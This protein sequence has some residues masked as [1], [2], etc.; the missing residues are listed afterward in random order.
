MYISAACGTLCMLKLHGCCCKASRKVTRCLAVTRHQLPLRNGHLRCPSAAQH[1]G[2]GVGRGAAVRAAG[3]GGSAAG[4][5]A[6]P[7]WRGGRHGAPRHP[8][9][10]APAAEGATHRAVAFVHSRRGWVMQSDVGTAGQLQSAYMH[11]NMSQAPVATSQ[12][13]QCVILKMPAHRCSWTTRSW[14]TCG[15][16]RRR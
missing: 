11:W 3:P 2:V 9:V 13:A 8:G 7:R 4:N 12:S 1:G 16:P 5:R 10:A 15:A 6:Q 14:R